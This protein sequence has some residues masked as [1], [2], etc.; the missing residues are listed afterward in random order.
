MKSEE[1]LVT[2][3]HE[4]TRKNTIKFFADF[5]VFRRL[6]LFFGLLFFASCAQKMGSQPS[7]K[8]LEASPVFPFS[9]SARPVVFGTI[10]S[11]WTRTNQRIETAEN[12]D[13][14]TNEL[15][16][17]LTE[18]VLMRGQERFE[19]NC[20]VCH[21]RA[22]EGDGMVARRGFSRPPTF[23]DDRLRNAPLGHFYDVITNGFGGMAS[24]ANQVEPRDRWA[25]AAY[26]RALQLSQNAS[27]DEVPPEKRGELEK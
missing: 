24:Y 14:N 5:R 25:I 10:P 18:E 12:F 16:F 20:A 15:P 11:G 1:R 23:H 2:K 13:K 19:I 27:V 3:K 9:Q 22:G 8:P 4:K 26:I 7:L 21:G 17:P 6:I